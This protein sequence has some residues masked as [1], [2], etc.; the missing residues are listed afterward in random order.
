VSLERL[1]KDIYAKL[2]REAYFADVPVFRYDYK[3][4]ANIDQALGGVGAKAGK[5][6]AAVSV[7]LPGLEGANPEVPGPTQLVVVT[8]RVQELPDLVTG[9]RAED[10]ALY[11]R[12]LLHHFAPGGE[13]QTLVCDT[14]AMNPSW[15][16]APKLTFDVRHY[17]NLNSVPLDKVK[18]VKIANVGGAISLSC[19]TAGAAIYYTINS[20]FPANGETGATLYSAPFA[21]P[22][23][24]TLIRAAASKSGSVGSNVAELTIE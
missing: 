14:Q 22:A 3:I 9:K 17:A 21:T 16:F 18:P 6:S 8:C 7:L 4:Q 13:V 11:I 2:N 5:I 10:V 24:G 1:Q 19:G 23:A 20:E 12:Q 15:V